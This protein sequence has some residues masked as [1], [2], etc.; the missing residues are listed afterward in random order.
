MRGVR[1]A[2]C[3]TARRATVPAGSWTSRSPRMPGVPRPLASGEK[4][5]VDLDVRASRLA[6]TGKFR[7]TR[8]IRANAELGAGRKAIQ[9]KQT[10]LQHRLRGVRQRDA[11][12]VRA[13]RRSTGLLSRLLQCPQGSVGAVSGPLWADNPASWAPGCPSCPGGAAYA[14]RL[15]HID[16]VVRHGRTHDRPDL[17]MARRRRWPITAPPLRDDWRRGKT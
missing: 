6:T 5:R 14:E 4:F 10:A 15:M 17:G 1:R 8:Q 13:A 9:R 11:G 3:C 16:F 2:V 12:S 7:D